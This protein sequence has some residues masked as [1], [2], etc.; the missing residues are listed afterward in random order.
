MGL[1]PTK[2]PDNLMILPRIFAET[3]RITDHGHRPGR[4]TDGTARAA[5]PALDLAPTALGWRST[6]SGRSVPRSR[7]VRALT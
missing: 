6:A 7:G 2:R 3:G 5:R 4:V 1:R